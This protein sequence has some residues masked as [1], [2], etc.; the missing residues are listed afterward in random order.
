MRIVHEKS[1]KLRFHSD[2]HAN[3][4]RLAHRQLA[5]VVFAV[6]VDRLRQLVG[7]ERLGWVLPKHA[8]DEMADDVSLRVLDRDGDIRSAVDGEVN[9]RGLT[10]SRGGWF[11]DEDR[12]GAAGQCGDNEYNGERKQ[13]AHGSRSFHCAVS[14]FS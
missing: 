14:G 12:V 10:G 1:I 4:E 3:A 11:L 6:P 2:L 13:L 5:I 7:N 9:L 8:G